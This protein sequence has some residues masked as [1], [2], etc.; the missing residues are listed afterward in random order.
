VL[1]SALGCK[2]FLPRHTYVMNE[3]LF[4]RDEM[5][6]AMRLAHVAG[7]I[8]LEHF[9]G[10]Q[11]EERKEDDTPVTI[12]DKAINRRV[13]EVLGAHFPQD[14][15]VGEEESSENTDQERRWFCDPI[16]GTKGYTYHLPLPMFSL[17][18]EVA[19]V[20]VLGVA[21]NPF[22]GSKGRL[23]TATT[24][25]RSLMNGRLVHVSD[26]SL[27]NGKVAVTSSVQKLV[28]ATPRHVAALL[29]RGVAVS[30]YPAGLV[31]KVCQVAMGQLVGVIQEQAKPH[32][33][34]AAAII[35]ERAGAVVTDLQGSRLNFRKGFEGV[36]VSN[37][38]PQTHEDLLAMVAS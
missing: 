22:I 35:A 10:D 11:G 30:G 13:I 16:D 7:R 29:D 23:H 32:D 20:P 9:E 5:A 6:V 12:A 27:D 15:V 25:G 36:V 24:G 3:S 31:F 37:G 14:G 38:T 28:R 26:Q 19:G 8:M 18:L 34:A 4:L 1:W 2:M 33:I 21:F 17:G